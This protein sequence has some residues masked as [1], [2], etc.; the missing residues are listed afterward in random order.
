E[1]VTGLDL[2]ELQLAVAAGQPLPPAVLQP[3]LSGHA[4]EVRLYAE[5]PDKGFLPQPGRLEQLVF[6]SGLPG[7]RV[8]SGVV[9]GQEITPY[10]D[11]MLAKIAAHGVDRAQAL[12]RLSAALAQC[13]VQ[14]TGPKG[15]RATNLAFLQKVLASAEFRSGNYDTGLA[16]SLQR[17]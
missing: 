11:P 16:E 1:L 14:L 9:A 13:T 3:T 7:V 17:V 10:Y 8:D 15:P 6:P 2:V 5:D 4:V 12:Q